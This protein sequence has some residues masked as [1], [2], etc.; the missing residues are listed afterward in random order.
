M[1]SLRDTH[2]LRCQRCHVRDLFVR[3]DVESVCVDAHAMLQV[4]GDLSLNVSSN[5]GSLHQ[6]QGEVRS[7]ANIVGKLDKKINKLTQLLERHSPL[8]QHL[9][10]LIIVLIGLQRPGLLLCG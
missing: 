9:I 5:Q 8:D 7:V 10:L 2:K 3:P 6:L 1:S 4:V